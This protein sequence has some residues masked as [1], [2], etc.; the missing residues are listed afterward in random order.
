MP[1]AHT[2][3]Q[4]SALC[5]TPE[6]KHEGHVPFHLENGW[7]RG[8]KRSPKVNGNE[9]LKAGM[10]SLTHSL[11]RLKTDSPATVSHRFQ[12]QMIL[13][14]RA[15]TGQPYKNELR[16]FLEFG[17]FFI[18]FFVLWAYVGLSGHFGPLCPVR[19]LNC[20]LS[21]SFVESSLNVQLTLFR[22]VVV[23]RSLYL[24]IEM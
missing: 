14:V 8:H 5:M 3:T 20:E 16:K 13:L 2:G 17:L 4:A 6:P 12:M 9:Q 21:Y 18:F 11:C 1:T 10:R 22:T 23:R 24:L 7:A 19:S 15:A